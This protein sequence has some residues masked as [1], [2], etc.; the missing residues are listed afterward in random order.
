MDE[1]F[2]KPLSL[3]CKPS[4]SLVSEEINVPP[5]TTALPNFSKYTCKIPSWEEK[6]H[7]AFS[8]NPVCHQSETT[9]QDLAIETITV[10][11]EMP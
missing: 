6:K 8:E 11:C 10:G 9:N 1:W 5:T 2:I 7:Q 4:H 3:H